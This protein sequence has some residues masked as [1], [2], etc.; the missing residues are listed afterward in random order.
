[1]HSS[2]AAIR[3]DIRAATVDTA[4]SI[5]F[6]DTRT[7]RLVTYYTIANLRKKK[8]ALDNC[9]SQYSHTTNF[10]FFETGAYL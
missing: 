5:L 10:I 9:D 4:I 1:M 8:D 2:C 6:Y 7:T 3:I